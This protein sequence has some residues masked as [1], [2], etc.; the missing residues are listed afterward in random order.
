MKIKKYLF[1]FIVVFFAHACVKDKLNFNIDDITI[2]PEYV[3]PLGIVDLTVKNVMPVSPN[4]VTD[5]D[6]SLRIYYMEDSLI[7][8]SALDFVTLPAV[9][10]FSQNI[11][12]GNVSLRNLEVLSI[13]SLNNMLPNFNTATQTALVAA[14]GN[15]T[16]FPVISPQS[17][18][19]HSSGNVSAFQNAQVLS[20]SAQ[21]QVVNNLPVAVSAISVNVIDI[22]NSH[23]YGPFTI[24]NSIGAGMQANSNSV[25]LSN[26]Q[27]SSNFQFQ[28]V[29]FST[30]GS[31]PGIVNVDLNDDIEMKLTVSNIVASTGNAAVA[32]QTLVNI[33]GEA[34][35]GMGNGEEL[36]TIE[37]DGGSLN[38]S[39]LSAYPFPVQVTIS[40]PESSVN[41][42]APLSVTQTVNPGQSPNWSEL[43][44][45]VNFDLGQGSGQ[46]FNVMP[47]SI[48][49]STTGSANA[50]SIV[51]GLTMLTNLSLQNMAYSYASG[52][53]GSRTV[54]LDGNSVEFDI[55]ILSKLSG[56]LYL[57]NP[58]IRLLTQNELGVRFDMAFDLLAE[59]TY[60]NNTQLLNMQPYTIP[61]PNPSQVGQNISGVSEYNKNNSSI[62]DFISVVPN[63]VEFVGDIY[64]NPQGN[65]NLYEDFCRVQDEIIIGLEAEFPIALRIQ[66]LQFVDTMYVEFPFEN[67]EELEYA[68]LYINNLNGFGLSAN[69]EIYFYDNNDVLLDVLDVGFLQS[70]ITDANGKVL[71]PT[72]T[73]NVIEL[74]QAFIQSV[75]N[76]TKV[77]LKATLNSPNNGNT[78]I[79][80]Y[81]YNYL[82]TY[83]GVEAK[84]K[85]NLGGN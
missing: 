18:G 32:P 44:N 72:L 70:A 4:L 7:R 66:D 57:D 74:D 20:A 30:P 33:T 67:P 16:I 80:L 82:R 27:L 15:N 75:Q 64:L 5:P 77:A 21:I 37:L 34:A 60:S 68:K 11:P 81:D 10:G 35:I 59:N 31:A 39:F 2:N 8:F 26:T 6:S 47:I 78:V 1:L 53:M 58:V 17:A 9:V 48:N 50:L 55:P 13:V 19:T 71:E 52:Y 12:L 85:L 29:S 42:G 40:F 36:K 51:Q 43:M 38:Y 83:L 45:N 61:Y 28:I 49:I 69:F 84:L 24:S 56:G 54:G 23:T 3:L 62:V 46:A 63:R 79:R 22:T 25:L 76:T 65:N 41:G 14:D 73:K